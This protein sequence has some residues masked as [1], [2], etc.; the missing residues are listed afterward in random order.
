MIDI[1]MILLNNEVENFSVRIIKYLKE[2]CHS[3]E[4]CSTKQIVNH[5]TRFFEHHFHVTCKLKYAWS[6]ILTGLRSWTLLGK[7]D[8]TSKGSPKVSKMHVFL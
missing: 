3:H 8:H 1:L 2:V 4:H 6:K 7:C 5:V